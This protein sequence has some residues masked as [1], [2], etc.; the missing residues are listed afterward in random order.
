MREQGFFCMLGIPRATRHLLQA[1]EKPFC[2]AA[3][4]SY[5]QG[6]GGDTMR[7]AKI[8]CTLGPST[9]SPQMLDRLIRAGMDVARLNFSHGTHE[10][11]ACAVAAVRD[12]SERLNQPV[13]V[14][15]DLQGPKIRVGNLKEP[16]ELIAGLSVTVTVGE[17]GDRKGVIPTTYR[18]LPGDV[19]PG[20][21]LLLDDGQLELRVLSV[22]GED[23][24]CEVVVGGLLKAHKGMNLPGVRVSAPSLTG[25]DREDLA[26]GIQQGVDFVALSFVRD[27]A[28][29]QEV[30]KLIAEAGAHIPVI[31]KLERAEAV[32]RLDAILD[33]A[34]GVMVARGDLGVELAPEQ[35]PVLQKRI[36]SAANRKGLLVITA[37]QMLESMT[38]NPRPTRAEASDVANAVFDGTDAVMLSGET[39]VGSYPEET[40]R[41][42]GRIVETAEASMPE[43]PVLSGGDGPVSFPDA[44]GQAAATAARA[45]GAKVIVA[46]T[47]SGATARLI[48]K[49][50]PK[51]PLIAFTPYQHVWRQLCLCWGTTPRLMDLVEDTDRMV[52]EVEARLLVEG[53]LEVGDT[54]AILAGA[55]IT[56]QAE[57]NLLKLHRVL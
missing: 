39:A 42:M 11:H 36:I 3:L 38:G 57:T 22:D 13:A 40:V 9:E 56:A 17:V 41:M 25:K 14:L 7:K 55:P 12:A 50:R 5:L 21:R 37:T 33:V 46:F 16:M 27:P 48:S 43:R 8:V 45:V 47:K 29:V 4:E 6:R 53:K 19:G 51:T 54:V 15:L 32:D 18:P 24:E 44:I 26:F 30:Q 10:Q 34:D 35:V 49:H 28:D 20:D 31:A 2:T 23:V 1:S 52:S